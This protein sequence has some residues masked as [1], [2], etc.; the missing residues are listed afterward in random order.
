MKLFEGALE[1]VVD[2]V[3]HISARYFNMSTWSPNNLG[4]KLTK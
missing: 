1:C 3:C 2:L 4:I